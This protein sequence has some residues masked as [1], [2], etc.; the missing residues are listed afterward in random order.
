MKKRIAL[1][2]GCSH[3]AGSEIDGSQDSFYNRANSFGSLLAKK[4]DRT[5][6]NIALTGGTNGSIARS[7]LNW[8]KD[9]YDPNTMDVF[10]IV[11]WT[12]ACRLEIP[13]VENTYH[14]NSGN[15]Y[16]D[17]F[18]GTANNYM[19]VIFGWDG[20]NNKEREICKFF[21]EVMAK[22]ENLMEVWAL[23]YILQI[24]YLLKSMDIDYV[25]TSAMPTFTYN[26]TFSKQYISLVDE[27]KYY[28]IAAT[29]ENTFYWKYKNLGY[30]NE[31]AQYW[32][33]G[34]EPHQ[35]YAEELYNFVKEK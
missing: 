20:A 30:E 16:T 14:Y 6:I 35:L 12:D 8:F 28:D 18:D 22:H 24:Q 33:H 3:A 34:L 32:H 19:R 9:Q 31:K 17:W 10:V 26:N 29:G 7:I 11:A 5:P 4:L 15:P 27:S 21:H 2:A 25:M 13:S 23:N 1:V